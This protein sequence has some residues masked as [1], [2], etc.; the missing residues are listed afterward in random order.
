MVM[1]PHQNAGQNRDLL[2][3]N[4]SFENVA[5]LKYFRTTITYQ[6]CIH[7]EI[8]NR[9]NKIYK[10]K[11]LPIVL[12]GCDTWSLTLREEHRL[13]VTYERGSGSGVE[14]TA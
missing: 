11:I 10:T 3:A 1:S 7:K 6:N 5:E 4:K 13:R 14:K 2:I 8:K 9:L 12:C